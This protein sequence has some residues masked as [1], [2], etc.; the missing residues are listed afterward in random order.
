M[1]IVDLDECVMTAL[2]L[3]IE[4][5]VPEMNLPDFKRPLV[6]G[7][8]NGAYT[9]RIM[10]NGTDAVFADE[11]SYE[12][13]LQNIPEIDGVILISASGEKHAPIIGK[14][15]KELGKKL[16]LLTC[17]PHASAKEYADETY[18]SPKQP[19]PY[20]YNTSTY[21]G[22]LLEHTHEN[23]K[24]I[25]QWIKEHIAPSLPKELASYPAYTIIVEPK[26]DIL[27]PMFLT[28]FD[29]L[30]GPMI[31]GRSFTSEQSKH[32][33]YVVQ[34]NGE[35]FIGLGYNNNNYG[36]KRYNVPLPDGANVAT[37]LAIGYY[38]IG[39]I[40]KGK[41]PWFKENIERYTKEASAIFGK[42][43]KPMVD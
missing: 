5:G 14:H 22:M 39:K 12:L 36:T 38:I 24:A 42:E 41:Q 20:T 33:K 28:K 11:G 13:A 30:F 7:S 27:R 6:V 32:A 15:V 3:F 10:Y 29:E 43:I 18:I 4:Q 31:V 19:E 16:I 34:S 17:N 26:F 8:V 1:N 35:L 40:Q 37:T 2:D 9:G 21:L 23:P 25:K